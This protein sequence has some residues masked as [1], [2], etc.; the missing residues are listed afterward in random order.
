MQVANAP[1]TLAKKFS[2][3]IG[4]SDSMKASPHQRLRKF[5]LEAQHVKAFATACGQL[6]TPYNR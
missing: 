1:A 3:F 6:I 4:L 5:V 2:T